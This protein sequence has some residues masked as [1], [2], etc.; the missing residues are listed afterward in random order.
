VQLERV[1]SPLGGFLR[2]L[3]RLTNPVRKRGDT[4]EDIMSAPHYVVDQIHDITTDKIDDRRNKTYQRTT[5]FKF[6]VAKI[7]PDHRFAMDHG[8]KTL[9]DR[10]IAKC[11]A[12]SPNEH[13]VECNH[14]YFSWSTYR[15]RETDTAYMTVTFTGGFDKP[16]QI[17]SEKDHTD[18]IKQPGLTAED[19]VLAA[20]QV[21]IK[22]ANAYQARMYKAKVTASDANMVGRHLATIASEK[23]LQDCRFKARLAGLVAEYQS[24]LKDRAQDL[25]A[26]DPVNLFD[27]V[28]EAADTEVAPSV[29]LDLVRAQF[30]EFIKVHERPHERGLRYSNAHEITTDDVISS[31]GDQQ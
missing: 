4:K 19:S 1:R 17:F 10:I 28:Y 15:G 13:R 29:I 3:L 12:L 23:A 14:P 30:K 18:Q 21:A 7:V 20:V 25:M 6:N 22:E 26:E 2:K 8:V 24:H 27:Q 9:R 5:S 31:M 11:K 16:S